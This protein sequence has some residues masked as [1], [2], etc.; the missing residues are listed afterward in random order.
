[1]I[2][3][4]QNKK[5]MLRPGESI[6]YECPECGIFFTDKDES[7]FDAKAL[8]EE[9]YN[10]ELPSSGRFSFGI[11]YVIRLF[12][13]FRAFKVSTIT[14]RAKR[15]LDIGSGRGLMLYYLKKYYNYRR[16]AGI[17]ISKNAVKFSREKLGLEIY[18]KDLLEV[19]LED[20]SFDVITMWHVL[21]HMVKPERYIKKISSLL[22]DGGSM[23]VE[24]PN[25][26]SWTR[27]LTKQYWLGLDLKHHI[28]FF[29]PDS[30][31]ALLKK[32]GFKIKKVH[33]FS[34]EYSTFISTQSI[35]SLITRSDNV[36]FEYLQTADHSRNTTFHL[37]LFAMLMP[38]CLLVNMLLFFSKR[39]EVLLIA[40]EK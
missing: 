7:V 38:V 4:H 25:F 24:V 39:G 36:F 14:P 26:N 11:E 9:Y 2:C 18:D 6:L 35:V 8:Y 34:L 29:T 33:T 1:M 27:R 10:N 40:A 12:R 19:P 30:L 13:F 16:A 32:H 3:Q 23:V 37:F 28:N 17:Q 22:A 20:S 21:E 5:E 31:S 15:I